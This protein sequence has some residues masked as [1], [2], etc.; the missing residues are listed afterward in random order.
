MNKNLRRALRF[1]VY[2]RCIGDD[3]IPFGHGSY[4]EWALELQRQHERLRQN[5]PP[6]FAA[7]AKASA[8]DLISQ[9]G[10]RR[11]AEEAQPIQMTVSDAGKPGDDPGGPV[12]EPATANDPSAAVLSAEERRALKRDD[13]LCRRK[14]C[15]PDYWSAVLHLRRLGPDIRIYECP[16]CGGLHLGHEPDSPRTRQYRRMRKRLRT[17]TKCLAALA[18]E[19]EALIR[20]RT[21]LSHEIGQPV[22]VGAIISWFTEA[23]QRLLRILRPRTGL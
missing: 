1:C 3:P 6:E 9:K 20:E 2:I 15:H 12:H 23:F 16:V 4:S 18:Q 13:Y 17:V 11:A 22:A 8:R 10:Y 21:Q 14:L 7:A 19:Q 5:V